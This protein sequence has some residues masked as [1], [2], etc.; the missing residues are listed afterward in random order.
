MQTK[1]LTTLIAA[2]KKQVFINAQQIEQT[3]KGKIEKKEESATR[4]SL[5]LGTSRNKTKIF[6][7]TFTYGRILGGSTAESRRLYLKG[8]YG[9]AGNMAELKADGIMNMEV[10]IGEKTFIEG[11]VVST[12]GLGYVAP[13]EKEKGMLGRRWPRDWHGYNMKN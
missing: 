7:P 13:E 8:P 11:R 3:T 10:L 1:M 4:M 12:I 2:K 5:V 9:Y 6:S